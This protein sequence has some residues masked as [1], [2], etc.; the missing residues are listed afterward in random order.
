MHNPANAVAEDVPA[1]SPAAPTPVAAPTSEAVGQ[2]IADQ[3]LQAVH[4]VLESVLRRIR[5]LEE[6]ERRPVP[7]DL[8]PERA[9]PATRERAAGVPP[10]SG[11]DR[12]R[13]VMEPGHVPP[14]PGAPVPAPVRKVLAGDSE[15]ALAPA[16]D[17]RPQGTSGP[18]APVVK[19]TPMVDASQ[20]TTADAFPALPSRG[21]IVA[22]PAPTTFAGVLTAGGY[23]DGQNVR[24]F[25]RAA[26]S[27]APSPPPL[28]P[29]RLHALSFCVMVGSMTNVRKGRCAKVTRLLGAPLLTVISRLRRASC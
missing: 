19:A 28:R 2:S 29:P 24:A 10:G 8:T 13:K 23:R 25:A 17:E 21:R 26:K 14:C 7:T 16:L 12:W 5:Y 6:V 27:A 3:V 1:T 20:L 15:A 22:A 18:T 11:Q 4:P 9:N